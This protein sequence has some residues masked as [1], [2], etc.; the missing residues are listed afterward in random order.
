M[1]TN[2]NN[3]TTVVNVG[4]T[5]PVSPGQQ[6]ASRSIPVVLASDQQPVPVEEQNKVQSEV[7]LSLLGIPRSEVALGIFADVNTYDVNPSE[8]S[9]QPQFHISGLGIKHLPNEAGALV[10]APR[11]KKA[12][13]T[14]KRFFRYQPGRVSA[15]TFGV[16]T[17]VSTAD[18][19]ANPVIRKYGIFD[20]FDGYY[21]ESRQSGQGD[22]FNVVRRTQ[23]LLNFPNSPFGNVGDDLRKSVAFES[24]NFITKQQTDDY[25]VCGKGYA[26]PKGDLF[27]REREILLEKKY[28]IAQGAFVDALANTT[29]VDS[30][31]STF[32]GYYGSSTVN[33]LNETKDQ[34]V[35]RDKCERDVSLWIDFFVQDLEWGGDAHTRLNSKNYRTALLPA[36]DRERYLH[37]FVKTRILAEFGVTTPA[38][39]KLDT[40]TNITLDLFSQPANT[41]KSYWQTICNTIDFG[42]KERLDTIFDTRGYYWAYFVSTYSLGNVKG[43]TYSNTDVHDTSTQVS[44]LYDPI[45]TPPGMEA[46]VPA[47]NPTYLNANETAIAGGPEG[48]T[49]E[50]AYYLN[51]FRDKIKYKCARD[52]S[53]VINGYK[54]DILG[55]GNAETKYNMSMYYRG[56]GQ[57]IYTQ[58]TDNQNPTEISRHTHLRDMIVK[59]LQEVPFLLQP[60]SPIE[61]K[62][63]RLSSDLIANFD[64]ESTVAVEYGSRGY[65]GNLIAYRDG[66]PMIHAAVNDPALLKPIKKIKAYTKTEYIAGSGGAANTSNWY[67]GD[68]Y[69]TLFKLTEGTVTFGQRV[70]MFTEN[71]V[72]FP[73]KSDGVQS[74]GGWNNGD[75][76]VV[77]EVYGTKGE[78]FTLKTG[79][80]GSQAPGQRVLIVDPNNGQDFTNETTTSGQN[81]VFFELVMPFEVP[82]EYNPAYYR[83][84]TRA[85]NTIRKGPG[86]NFTNETASFDEESDPFIKGMQWPLVYSSNVQLD[87]QEALYLG[88]IDTALDPNVT[89]NLQQIRRAYDDINFNIEYL[90]WIKNNVDPKYWGVYEY[91]IPRSRFTH[92]K[93]DG[94]V[95]KRVY[96][97]VATGPTGIV[98]P[99]QNVLD[100]DGIWQ[101]AESL[102]NFDFTKVTM[103]KVEFSWYGAVGGLFLAYVPINNGEARWV[104]V[105]HLRAS[106]QL[107]IASLGNA[108]L[109]ITYNVWGGGDNQTGGDPEYLTDTYNY[110]N[111]SHHIVKY[112]ASYYIDGGDRGTV[113]LYSHNN[114]DTT[115]AT[116]KRWELSTI[117]SP[118]NG[119]YSLASL[120][121]TTDNIDIPTDTV[122]FMGADLKTNDPRDTGIK[123]KWAANNTVEFTR[124]PVGTGITLITDRSPITYGLETK[125]IIFSA[126]DANGVRNRVQVYPTKLS[127]ANLGD[128]PVRLRMKKTP[129]FQTTDVTSGGL[130]LTSEYEITADNLPLTVSEDTPPY[131]L[132]NGEKYGWFKGSVLGNDVTIFGRLYKESNEYYFENYESFTDT[133]TLSVGYFLP[134]ER[135]AHV[136]NTVSGKIEIVNYGVAETATT[137]VAS[138]TLTSINVINNP[139]VPIPDT[140][141][142]IATLY[143]TPGTEQLELDTYFDYNKEYLSF[144]L[145]D[146]AESLYFAVDSDT[147][148]G[149]NTDSIAIGTTWEEQ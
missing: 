115:E 34:Y 98:R 102:Y 2:V 112:G 80:Y 135:F 96:S 81:C 62:I 70:R 108:T 110:G 40:L 58:D 127:T 97:D 104:R 101:D 52:V 55:G 78:Y 47:T 18:F 41:V 25:R 120:T 141:I 145:T 117:D 6:P 95:S 37:S 88:F 86:I 137:T 136:S 8:W 17:T 11:N 109:P 148:I 53:Y 121:Q 94:T 14:S 42:N 147:K 119:E 31:G 91:R 71:G 43:G 13:L 16:K 142:N 90:N 57:S 113:R 143:L 56:D 68:G 36:P 22:N 39:I 26:V 33:Y 133:V 19:A 24:T 76:F 50:Q 106:N 10:E 79:K 144:P 73:V 146:E 83:L 139:V 129:I 60:G 132:N 89:S 15:A 21:W 38:Y 69:S 35:K 66:L 32:A 138:D 103:L 134:D 100:E 128:N 93:L 75:T 28:E 9:S 84:D 12:I 92:D 130:S 23:S 64:E 114:N 85:A 1:A 49:P 54:N 20:N 46:L 77:S 65:A 125:D 61:T 51:K 74:I 59:D 4:R 48:Y 131:L 30:T 107:K 99:G 67:V 27:V 116:G 140:G 5:T 105:H 122:Y 149:S 72:N 45:V 29:F 111:G 63:V 124:Q 82:Q 126:V 118:T 44:Y 3:N 123:V 7:S 87:D